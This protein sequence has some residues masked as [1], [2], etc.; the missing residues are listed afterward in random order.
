MFGFGCICLCLMARG[1]KG[2]GVKGLGPPPRFGGEKGSGVKGLGPPL[3]FGWP[4]KTN[5][6]PPETKEWG[7]LA[8]LAKFSAIITRSGPYGWT[9][10]RVP[11]MP[12]VLFGPYGWTRLRVPSTADV[13]CMV[14]PYGWTKPRVPLCC[15]GSFL[16]N[17]PYG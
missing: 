14:G 4:P 9:N 16:I 2:S 7:H 12:D 6:K 10:L 3:R 8:P 11:L 13:L 15:K 17:V 1:G 5:R